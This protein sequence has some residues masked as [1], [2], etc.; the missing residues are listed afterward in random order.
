M[1]HSLRIVYRENDKSIVGINVF[2]IRL[3]HKIFEAWIRKSKTVDYVVQNLRQANFDPEFFKKFEP[4]I[5]EAFQKQ[6][7]ETEK[8]FA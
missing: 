6:N 2:G 3:R 4:R 5:L 7:T 1:K 8:T